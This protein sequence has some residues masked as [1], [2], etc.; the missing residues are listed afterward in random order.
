VASLGQEAAFWEQKASDAHHTFLDTVQASAGKWQTAIAAFLGAYTTAGF[1]IA[2]SAAANLPVHGTEEVVLLVLYG[3]AGLAGITAIFL[4]NLAN[5]G[6]PQILSGTPITG[7]T[8]YKL[9]VD[10]ATSA[11]Q[12]LNW[13]IRSAATAGLLIVVVS[14]SV[15]VGGVSSSSRTY[16]RWIT[17][18]GAYCGRLVDPHGVLELRL[19]GGAVKE[20]SGGALSTITTCP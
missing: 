16:A 4:A 18:T 11:H 13:A 7:Q 2:P 1:L 5:Q 12:R 20:V 19:A 17:T 10:R 14:V 6:I 9:T 15:L 3:L 8:L